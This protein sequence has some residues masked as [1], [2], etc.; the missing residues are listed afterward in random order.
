MPAAADE[1]SAWTGEIFL[2]PGSLDS[3]VEMNWHT[4][5][6]ETAV[7]CPPEQEPA[8]WAAIDCLL[9]L[10]QPV[11]VAHG[12][13]VPWEVYDQVECTECGKNLDPGEMPEPIDIDQ[14]AASLE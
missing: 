12:A 13:D 2:P 11:L 9:G 1:R 3:E 5:F 4:T 8:Y 14:L 7:P 10:H 6:T